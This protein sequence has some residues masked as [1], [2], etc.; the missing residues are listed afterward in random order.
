M[1]TAC[2]YS[3]AQ[4]DR[5]MKTSKLRRAFPRAIFDD[6]LTRYTTTS[7]AS[8]SSLDSIEVRLRL[9]YTFHMAEITSDRRAGWAET[10]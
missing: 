2:S 7:A 10:E 6:R 8:A 5:T 9:V 4:K 3:V 1:P